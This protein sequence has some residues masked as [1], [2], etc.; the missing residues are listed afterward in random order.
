VKD[1][2]NRTSDNGIPTLVVDGNDVVAVFRVAQE[3]IR[4]AR[5]GHGPSLIECKTQRWPT[6]LATPKPNP[7]I[8]SPGS[9][10]PDDP[11]CCMETYLEKKGLWS[12]AWKERLV[13]SF[14]KQ[15]DAAEAFAEQ[16]TAKTGF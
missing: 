13:S 8:Q 3:A 14:T 15:L 9:R 2:D 5:E 16:S 11:I 12:E 7:S 4:R 1:I 10:P 6:P